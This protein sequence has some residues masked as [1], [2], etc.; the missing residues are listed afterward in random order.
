MQITL[1]YNFTPRDYQ[2]PILKILDEGKHK[3]VIAVWHRRSGKDKT[4]LNYIFKKMF[5]RVGVYYYFFPTYKQGKKILWHGIDRDGFKFMDH[6][7]EKLVKSMNSQEM[8]METINGSIF[9]VIGTDNIDSIVGT[10]PVGC[11]FSEYS[12][13]DP[14][15]WDFIRPILAENGGFA[16]FN[17][18]PRGKNHGY[19][20]YQFAKND[21]TW[22]AEKLTAEDTQAIPPQILEQE[23][24]EI[25]AKNGNDSLFMQ[26]YFCSFDVPVEGAY[27][28]NQLVEAEKGGRITNIPY[29]PALS[30][31]TA[32][33]LGIGDSTAIWFY[34]ETGQEIRFIDY[35]ETNGESL[36]YYIKYLQDKPYVYGEHIAPHDI[37]V[38]E[39][40]TGKTRMDTARELG[41]YFQVADKL[42]ID[43]GIDAARNI[44]SRCWFDELK[45]EKGL[46]ALRSY[47]KEFDEKN[48]VYK[49]KPQHDWSSH[50]A[51]AFRYFAVGYRKKQPIIFKSTKSKWA[52]G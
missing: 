39:L 3:R 41:I 17:Y 24:K 30:V 33:D 34:Q 27:Y 18:T 19:Y 15:A 42:P 25:I 43:D 9:Q 22:Y 10:N 12:L 48:E 44:L 46:S 13:Q 47:H 40:T 36:N 8:F 29:D 23:K 20:L 4:F 49:N 21:P 5:E 35:Y 52:I 38:R 51:D 11:V 2:K 16:L 14:R 32:W 45:C 31:H 1:P 28:G 37:Q 7:P 50:G 6:M 26:E